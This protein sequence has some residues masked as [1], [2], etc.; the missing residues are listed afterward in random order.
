M[1]VKARAITKQST[2]EIKY[3]RYHF[4]LFQISSFYHELIDMFDVFWQTHHG[5]KITFY[6]IR[7]MYKIRTYYNFNE[8]DNQDLY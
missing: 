4:Q 7:K 6:L 5:I 1:L 2:K 3:V 8:S